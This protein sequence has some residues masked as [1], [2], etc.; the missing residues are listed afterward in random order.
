MLEYFTPTYIKNRISREFTEMSKT[1]KIV[2][3]VVFVVLI[4]TAAYMLIADP[5]AV[6]TGVT[7]IVKKHQ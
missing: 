1:R 4:G 3:A 5:F 6:H 7:K 2:Y